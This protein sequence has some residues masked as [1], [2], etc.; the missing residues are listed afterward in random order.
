MP[1]GSS[2]SALSPPTCQR[3]SGY[4]PSSGAWPRRTGR[5]L[6]LGCPGQSATVLFRG[7]SNAVLGR[8]RPGHA[9]AVG[10]AVN[11]AAH[12]HAVTYDPDAAVLASRGERVD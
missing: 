12:L 1:A 8:A 3:T 9:R 5:L 2:A 7:R 4:A 6:K 10:A 11:G